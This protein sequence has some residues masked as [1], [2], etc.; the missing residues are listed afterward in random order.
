MRQLISI[1]GSTAKGKTDFAFQ[2]AQNLTE[3]FSSVEIISAD[4]RQVYKGMEIGTGVDLPATLPSGVHFFGT[5]LIKPN[6]EWSVAHFRNYAQQIL[7]LSWKKN[8][9]P[10]LVGGTG[11]YHR[12]VLSHDSQL[13]V[14]PNEHV[15]KEAEQKNVTELQSWLQG[16]S[17]QKLST[18]FAAQSHF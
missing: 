15:R 17:A 7:E 13:M 18:N 11:L 2:V 16:L 4:S 14:K 6:E 12:Q 3:K 1:V 10:I 5:S 8:A 9:R